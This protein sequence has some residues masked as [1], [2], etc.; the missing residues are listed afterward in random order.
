MKPSVFITRILPEPG[1]RLLRGRFDLTIFGKPAPIDRETLKQ[2]VRESD[3]LICLLSDRIDAEI[4]DHGS[5]LKI[6]AN[7]AVGYNNIDIEAARERNIMVTNTPGVLTNATAELAFALIITLT[8]RILAADR[9]TRQGEF[10][11]W[12]PLLFLGDELAGKT[13]GIVGL[14]RIGRSLAEKSRA[15]GMSVIYYNRRPLDRETEARLS[16]V[17]CPF[18]E[19]LTRAD[20][21]SIHAPLTNETRG[22]F[23]RASFKKIKPGAYLINTARGEIIDEAALAEA[24]VS[25]RLKGAGL[26]VY[27][28]EPAITEALM[29]LDNVVLLPHIGSATV[30]TRSNMAVLAVENVIAALEGRKPRN[31]VPE[32]AL[33]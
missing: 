21:I 28:R 8:R 6:V 26:D 7:Y 10:I 20:V 18:E 25:G 2:G 15:F 24:L 5:R 19:L 12:D 29:K 33:P 27:E 22:L 13:L 14:G 23:N 16:A 9:L 4:M 30:E 31:L 32:M 11:G 3:A 17:Y 1:L